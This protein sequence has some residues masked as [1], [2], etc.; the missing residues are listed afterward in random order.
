MAVTADARGD[1]DEIGRGF[2]SELWKA[3][4]GEDAARAFGG[5]VVEVV[6]LPFV[7]PAQGRG[8]S[9][10]N[11][12]VVGGVGKAGSNHVDARGVEERELAERPAGAGGIAAG[13][14]DEADVAGA[15]AGGQRETLGPRGGGK[16]GANEFAEVLVAS[17]R[18]GDGDAEFASGCLGG[19]DGGRRA[20]I[21]VVDRKSTRLNSS[22]HVISY[23]V[24]C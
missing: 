15:G 11:G 1:I 13:D 21:A 4:G 19:G 8:V 12:S 3:R 17:A 16:G 23:A 24:F 7:V 18:G 22:H 14:K 20:R 5:A 6:E 9:D 10:E 2:E